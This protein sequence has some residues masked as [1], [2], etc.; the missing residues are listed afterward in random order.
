MKRLFG[1]FVA[2]AAVLM[3]V[4]SCQKETSFETGGNPADATL[5]SDVSGDCLPKNVAGIY[6]AGTALDATNFIEVDMQVIGTGDYTVYTDT[7][8]GVYFRLQGTFTAVGYQTLKLKGF[9]T[10]AIDGSFNFR[11]RFQDQECV[12]PVD[13][14]PAGAGG[15]AIFTLTGTGTPASCSGATP[16]GQYI[17]GSPLTS[18][19][20]VPLT[21]NVTQIGT[22]TI[23]TTAV[24]GM[25]FTKS[26]TFTGTG[27]QT[28]TLVGSGTPTGTAGPVTIPV[29]AGTSTCNFTVTTVSGAAYTFNCAGATVNGTYEKGV[30]LDATNTIDVPVTV[31][32]AGPYNISA[33]ING[34]TFTASGSFTLASTSV[35]L[36]GA[37]TPTADG[38][39]NLPLAGTTPC[40]VSIVVDPAPASLG[41]WSFKVGTTTYSGTFYDAE[42]D[43][44]SAP[45]A[46]IFAC[47]GDNPA[48]EDLLLGMGDITPITGGVMNNNEVYE[49]S[50]TNP[51]ANIG[52]FSFTGIAPLT[53]E[54]DPTITGVDLKITVVTHNVATKTI[55]GTFAGKVQDNTGAFVTV[56]NGTFTVTYP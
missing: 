26:G 55:T 56:T 38:T 53:Y 39:F 4:V 51:T 14:L 41:T 3:F 50:G 5:Q 33:T 9:G 23:T 37:G 45:P 10:P 44:T 28:V 43:N 8:N 32:T 34:M 25:T 52:I 36:T 31:T 42:F 1:S 24:N 15:P 30:A 40:T 29:T 49:T 22:Y 19:N 7:V 46:L 54:A 35:T 47:A 17:I 6:E 27:S 48:G 13:F 16:N 12:I 21:V 11:V 20:T 2:V 18:A